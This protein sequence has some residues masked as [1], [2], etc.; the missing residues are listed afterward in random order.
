MFRLAVP[1]CLLLLCSVG[2]KMCDTIH[3][4]RITGFVDRQDDY[5]GFYPDYR[6]G[7]LFSGDKNDMYQTAYDLYANAGNYGS[8]ILVE[9][10]H[11]E[12]DPGLFQRLPADASR[13]PQENER[14]LDFPGVPIVPDYLYSPPAPGD[15]PRIPQRIPAIPEL[16]PLPFDTP[17]GNT[18]TPFSQNDEIV[19]PPNTAPS[20][21]DTELP[22][23]L[24]ELRR[25]D[26]SVHDIQIISIEDS[27]V[28]MPI[29]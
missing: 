8:T 1:L 14:S 24:E 11:R 19:T 28:D 15:R 18:T 29:R 10:E 13:Q 7:S 22:I 5:R 9:V 2:C 17:P 12:P 4:C 3:D 16:A 21:Q 20:I 25:L 23:T 6:A 27:A 26:P